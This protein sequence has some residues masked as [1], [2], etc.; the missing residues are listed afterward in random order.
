MNKLTKWEGNFTSELS[1]LTYLNIS[2]NPELTLPTALLRLRRLKEIRGV[3]WNEPC[4]NCM[5]VRNYTLENEDFN[6]E[7]INITI[8]ELRKGEYIVGKEKIVG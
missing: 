6:N 7:D 3:T 2:S 4:S 8:P 1:S 5:L